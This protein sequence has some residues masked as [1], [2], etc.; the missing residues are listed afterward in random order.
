MIKIGRMINQK[1]IFFKRNGGLLLQQ[2]LASHEANIENTTLFNS[3]DLEK[4]IDRFNVNRI[5]DQGGQGTI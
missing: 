4:A 2:Q 5:L 1:N 3:N